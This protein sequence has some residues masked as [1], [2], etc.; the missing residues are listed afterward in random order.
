[1]F[2]G[3]L[4]YLFSF[5]LIVVL[6]A[7]QPAVAAIDTPS[8]SPQPP[9]A[10]L[11]QTQEPVTPIPTA[12]F[13]PEDII[14]VWTRSDPERGDLFI[15]INSDG[16]YVASH[17]SPDGIT[18]SG[19]YTVDGRIFTFVDGWDCSSEADIPGQYVIRLLSGKYLLFAPYNDAC[20]DRPSA[21]K[22]YRWDRMEPTPTP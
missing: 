19:S 8:P 22:S 2:T 1:M 17:G 7:C 10:T 20:P 6:S 14:G 11:T 13:L 12:D 16:S 21:F 9:Q 4:R 3:T 15:I 18:H 5:V